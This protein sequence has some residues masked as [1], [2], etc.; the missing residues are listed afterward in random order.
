M[1][2]ELASNLRCCKWMTAF[3]RRSLLA[4]VAF[5]VLAE[6][7][8]GVAAAGTPVAQ[9]ARSCSGSQWVGA[10]SASPSDAVEGTTFTDQTL[11]MV[12]TPHFGGRTLRVRLSNRFG[13]GE[14]RL[15]RVRIGLRRSRASVVAGS[16]RVVRFGGRRSVRLGAG[17]D[18]VSDRVRL[19]F[20]AF[21]DLAVSIYAKAPTGPP[22]RHWLARQTSYMTAPGAGNRTGDL[23]GGAFSQTTT[24]WYFLS[25]VDVRASSRVGSVVAFGD[26]ITDG[27][28]GDNSPLIEN[29]IGI[30]KNARY[31]DFLARRLA[32][33]RGPL[34][35]SVLNAGIGGNRVLRDGLSQIFGPRGISRLRRDVVRL[36]GVTDAI[37]MEGIN[38]IGQPPFASARGL[39]AGLRTIARRLRARGIRV[40]LATLTP[41]GGTPVFT[42]F[43]SAEADATR[44]R[45]NRWIR[46]TRLADD[47]IDFDAALRDPR[48]RSRLRPRYDSS[49]H[50][51]PSTAGYRRMAA[52]VKLRRLQGPRC[53]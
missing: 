35:L 17:S 23:G 50:L 21:Q 43:G 45:V 10:W 51:H 38:D 19:R 39:I 11:R 53:R 16:S 14:V 47:V 9:A 30:D 32:R 5:A 20:R 22:T 36:P 34:R 7:L 44:R 41:A 12:I 49:D 37:V 24:S 18:V 13:R 4:A 28:Q 26:S 42:A 15:E 29:P 1:P 6:C 33:L 27:V 46:T 3:G 8:V 25:G 40:H 52:A 31:P 48:D 2:S